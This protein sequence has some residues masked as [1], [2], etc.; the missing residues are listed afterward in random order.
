VGVDGI[1]ID[2]GLTTHHEVEAHTNRA[3]ISRARR[4]I[5]V[6]DSSKIGQVAFARICGLEQVDEVISDADADPDEVAR[7]RDAGVVLT[8]V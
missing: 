4:V 1:A 5:V 6:T 8:L 3:L 2:A 7:L